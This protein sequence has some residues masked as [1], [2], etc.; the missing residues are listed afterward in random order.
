M[1]WYALLWDDVDRTKVVHFYMANDGS[2]LLYDKF[3]D[4]H[5]KLKMDVGTRIIAYFNDVEDARKWLEKMV[6]KHVMIL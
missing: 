1:E 4:F 6:G 2:G 5:D 3:N